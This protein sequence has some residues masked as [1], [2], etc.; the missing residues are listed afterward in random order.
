MRLA[1]DTSVV[2]L[3]P[4]I[5]AGVKSLEVSARKPDGGTEV[6]LFAKDFA[7]DWPT[8]Y[9]LKNPVT[10]PKGAELFVTASGPVRL[11]VSKY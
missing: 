4:E 9:V 2:S 3:R 6:L 5:G 1:A 7:P 11:T 8:P 10:L